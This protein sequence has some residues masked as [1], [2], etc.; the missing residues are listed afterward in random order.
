M[1]EITK[2][3]TGRKRWVG[4]VVN[5][6][7]NKTIKVQIEQIFMHPLYKKQVR[8]KRNI[9]VHDEKNEARVG[10]RVEVIESRPLSRLKRWRLV[11]II[12]RPG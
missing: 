11:K 12:E 3:R 2:P 9:L 8:K 7:C 4:I 5:D 1:S 6:K 10:D